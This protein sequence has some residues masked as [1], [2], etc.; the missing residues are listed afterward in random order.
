MFEKVILVDEKD[1]VVG[2]EEKV[3]AHSKRLRHRAFSIFVFNSKGEILLQKRA[4][5]KYHSGGL[6]SNACCGHPRPGEKL[7]RATKRRL[8]EEMGFNCDLKFLFKFR[9]RI[10]FGNG[11]SENEFDHVFVGKRDD[12]PIPNPEEVEEWKF[13]TIK[14]L[15]DDMNENPNKYTYWFLISIE[16]VLA[17]LR[18][19]GKNLG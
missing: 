9:Y 13:I 1:I 17:T 19:S 5:N 15:K 2:E 12:D 4:R 16:N 7:E 18:K 3:K 11:L 6:W 14:E 10:D 8:E